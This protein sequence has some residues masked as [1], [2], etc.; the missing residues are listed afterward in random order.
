[1][2]RLNKNNDCN[3]VISL[4]LLHSMPENAGMMGVTV[5][6]VHMRE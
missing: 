2:I 6:P 3:Q 4:S 5:F 1:M